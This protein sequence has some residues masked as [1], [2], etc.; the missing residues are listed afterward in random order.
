MAEP[1][2]SIPT[3]SYPDLDSKADILDQIT[4]SLDRMMKYREDELTVNECDFIMETTIA[5]D[6]MRKGEPY[7]SER[8]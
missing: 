5:V 8:G 7:W 1:T 6:S 2:T 4:R 3:T